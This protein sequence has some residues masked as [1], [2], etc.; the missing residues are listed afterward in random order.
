MCNNNFGFKCAFLHTTNMIMYTSVNCDDGFV[1]RST[2]YVIAY[3]VQWLG[4][5]DFYICRERMCM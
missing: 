5:Y 3:V 2:S 4:S 1:V